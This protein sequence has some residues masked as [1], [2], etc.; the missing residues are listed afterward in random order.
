MIVDTMTK[1]FTTPRACQVLNNDSVF[2]LTEQQDFSRVIAKQ[3]SEISFLFT[4]RNKFYS[5][6]HACTI[7]FVSEVFTKKL[8]QTRA[9]TYSTDE[10]FNFPCQNTIVTPKI[11]ATFALI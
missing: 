6:N 8:L 3:T 4:T 5:P 10:V 7:L 1:L 9:G 2:Y 11:A